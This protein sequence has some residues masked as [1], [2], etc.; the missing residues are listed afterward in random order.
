M[1]KFFFS[2]LA[3][4][5]IV[6]CTKSEVTYEG[7]SEIAFAPVA[8]V[9]TKANVMHAIDGT[10]YPIEET[11]KVF[12]YWKNDKVAGTDH[13][14]FGGATEY[15]QGKEFA[16]ASDGT[17]WRGAAKPYYWPKTGSMVF[18]CLSP[19]VDP[20]VT[21]ITHDVVNDRFSFSYVSPNG[22]G[23]VDPSKTVD[24]MWT[25][26]TDSYSEET[27]KSGVPV[28]FKHALTWITFMV[29]GDAVTSGGNF[30]IKSLTMND[31]NIMGK[32]T[33]D[34]MKWNNISTP[35]IV[36]VFKGERNLTTEPAVIE[37]VDRGSL[38]IPQVK[39]DSDLS[40]Y[41]ATINFTNKLGDVNI[42]EVV[43]ISL[44]RGWEIGKHYIYTIKF[45]ASEILIEPKMEDWIDVDAGT[46]VL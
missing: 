1:K 31:V 5:A 9:A 36:P 13:S 2:I 25:N 15:I 12:A 29:Q 42:D 19:N 45:T 28:T 40:N 46:Q 17:L 32:F 8:S 10:T 26:T 20:Q 44:G 38:I 16:K 34:D 22:G 4:G 27:G 37:N 30:V 23:K 43:N 39:P 41:T 7:E 35:N 14:E 24:V 18:A 6:A 11:F 3:V 33:S 21:N